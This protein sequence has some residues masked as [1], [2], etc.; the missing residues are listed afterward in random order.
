MN[1]ISVCDPL[2]LDVFLFSGLDLHAHEQ[3]EK[4][5]NWIKWHD[6]NKINRPTQNMF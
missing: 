5:E 3:H 6:R 2:K 1:L 4:T